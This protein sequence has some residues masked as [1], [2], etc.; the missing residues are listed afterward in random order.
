MP[1]HKLDCPVRT[2]KIHCW[3]S[4]PLLQHPATTTMWKILVISRFLILVISGNQHF[5]TSLKLEEIK[6]IHSP[7]L[8]SYYERHPYRRGN[9]GMHIVLQPLE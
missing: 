9:Y 1:E 5:S 2:C 8:N 4:S 7:V 3:L 6:R